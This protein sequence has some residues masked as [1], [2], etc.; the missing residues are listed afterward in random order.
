MC[1]SF[2]SC[3]T[4]HHS[5]KRSDLRRKRVDLGGGRAVALRAARLSGY[6]LCHTCIAVDRAEA[7]LCPYKV[8]PDGCRRL[9]ADDLGFIP[10]W[11]GVWD[12]K[13]SPKRRMDYFVRRF[14][15]LR[16]SG[17]R[18]ALSGMTRRWGALHL[19]KPI[20]QSVPG[21]SLSRPLS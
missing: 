9:L 1:N 16:I 4:L 14:A 18:G 21:G 6:A 11:M 12:V 17:A 10:Q 3:L 7:C 5:A 8:I 15:R 20:A 2:S 13:T 19:L